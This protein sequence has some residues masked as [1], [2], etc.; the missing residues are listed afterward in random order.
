MNSTIRQ[1]N[2]IAMLFAAIAASLLTAAMPSASHV[3]GWELRTV[4]KEVPGTREIES[5]NPENS[6]IDPAG[7]I[8][9]PAN[10]D[11]LLLLRMCQVAA[12]CCSYLQFS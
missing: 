8:P 7:K 6:R 11:R 4:T 10:P 12:Y 3:E 5:G 2:Q 1:T 9:S